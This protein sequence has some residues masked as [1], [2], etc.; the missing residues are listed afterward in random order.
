MA[1]M[2]IKYVGFILLLINIT[3]SQ[4]ELQ[5][6]NTSVKN[7][8]SI[9]KL[10]NADTRQPVKKSGERILDNPDLILNRLRT[11]PPPQQYTFEFPKTIISSFNN[12]FHFAGF[13][14]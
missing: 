13:W 2:V 1:K 4:D 3:A 5:S 6:I 8:P 10:D 11:P 14:K 7:N 9:I 12:N